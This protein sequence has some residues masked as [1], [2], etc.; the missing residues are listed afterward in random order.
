MKIQFLDPF[1]RAWKRMISHLFK[2]FNLKTWLIIGFAAFLDQ[3]T[4]FYNKYDSSDSDDYSGESL[5]EILEAPYDAWEWLTGHPDWLN[6]LIGGA[7]AIF[8]IALL[9]TWLSS[10]GK[11]IFLDNIV[12][13]RALIRKPWNELRDVGNSLFFWR[14][15]FGV[16]VV[17]T[18]GSFLV[19]TYFHI[20]EM[21][22][23]YASDAEMLMSALTRGAVLVIMGIIT[24]YIAL[25]LSDFIVPI[26]YKNA[27]RTWIAWGQFIP[28]LRSNI[29]YFLAYG[30]F[31]FLLYIIFGVLIAIFGLITCCIG[32]LIL[33]IPYVGSVLT[34][35][36]SYTFRAFTVEFL[37]QFGPQYQIFN[38]AS[39]KTTRELDYTI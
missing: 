15:G 38:G 17:L 23:N 39:G 30:L 27:I 16:I 10:R 28:T 32:F 6:L 12:N 11:F 4:D 33:V 22:Q 14:F 8:L 37:Q 18:F 13:K 21:Y 26:M 5:G 34:L 19:N 7:I 24:A 3:L 35:P 36:V 1:D 29:W 31:R 25:F 20:Y 9:F 2:P